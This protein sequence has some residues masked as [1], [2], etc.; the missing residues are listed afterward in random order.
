LTSFALRRWSRVTSSGATPKM[1]DATSVWMSR[2]SRKACLSASS[3]LIEARMR[4]S[5]CT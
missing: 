3:P 1:R 2:P 4:S 5:I